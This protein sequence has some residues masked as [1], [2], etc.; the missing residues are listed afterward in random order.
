MP[1]PSCFYSTVPILYF[2]HD[3]WG[4]FAVSSALS[5]PQ[6]KMIKLSIT[7]KYKWKCNESLSLFVQTNITKLHA[8]GLHP[9]TCITMCRPSWSQICIMMGRVKAQTNKTNMFIAKRTER[10]WG[11]NTISYKCRTYCERQVSAMSFFQAPV[12]IT[13]VIIISMNVWL[14]RIVAVLFFFLND[15]RCSRK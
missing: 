11:S 14:Y 6:V 12:D 7:V 9:K 3:R 10:T 4:L 13:A 2:S 8:N 5:S 15:P 1:S